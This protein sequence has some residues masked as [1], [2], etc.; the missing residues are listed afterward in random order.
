MA[1]PLN[2]SDYF[3]VI[4]SDLISLWHQYLHSQYFKK[5]REGTAVIVAAV[6]I[7]LNYYIISYFCAGKVGE[8]RGKRCFFHTKL[9][10]L[11]F[12]LRTLNRETRSTL[13]L[14]AFSSS[15]F[16]CFLNHYSCTTISSTL[17]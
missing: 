6:I 2:Q 14:P 17:A 9:V 11:H 13:N 1:E 8:R 5:R 3:I 4:S 7:S 10:V 16:L 12:H 15:T